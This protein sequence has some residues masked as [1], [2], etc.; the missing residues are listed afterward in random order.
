VI[1]WDRASIR[2]AGVR[3]SRLACDAWPIRRVLICDNEDVM[4]SLVRDSLAEGEFELLEARDGDQALQ[5]A[6]AE[7]PDLILLDLM[8]PGRSG[9]D[10]LRELRND[11]AL[12]DIA[13]VM[14]SARALPP[15]RE[16]VAAAGAD[17]FLAKPFSPMRL[18]ALVDEL[19]NA[20]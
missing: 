20:R 7:H 18:V 6:R 12:A 3:V 15:D 19:L 16:A 2:I 1:A 10:V 4:R 5:L 17:Y 14:L 13:V 8:M 11:P 9:L